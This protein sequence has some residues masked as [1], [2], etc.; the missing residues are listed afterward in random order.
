MPGIN[1]SMGWT[2]LGMK[3][4]SPVLLN[5]SAIF[6]DFWKFH[7]APPGC[8]H[9]TSN[10]AKNIETK[11]LDA[12]KMHSTHY[13]FWHIVNGGGGTSQQ[14]LEYIP[15]STTISHRINNVCGGRRMI[16]LGTKSRH[17]IAP[18]QWSWSR[19]HLRKRG[20]ALNFPELPR[21]PEGREGHRHYYSALLETKLDLAEYCC[22]CCCSWW[23]LM[24]LGYH[25]KVSCLPLAPRH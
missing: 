9:Y 19:C 11:S 14:K 22:C 21:L 4:F 6:D 5:I 10:M 23:A 7:G 25:Q 13:S 2:Q 17:S 12:F 18:F 1:E 3:I 20:H 15:R 16:I 8:A 24:L